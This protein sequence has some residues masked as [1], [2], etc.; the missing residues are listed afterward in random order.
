MSIPIYDHLTVVD[1][2]DD[3]QIPDLDT[4]YSRSPNPDLSHASKTK[5]GESI[6][7]IITERQQQFRAVWHDITGLDKVMDRLDNIRQQLLDKQDGINQSIVLHRGCTS[8]LWRFPP[9]IL[10][11][12]FVHCLPAETDQ[13]CIAPEL[14]PLL[15]TRVCRPWKEV[16]VNVPSLW[17]TLSVIQRRRKSWEETFIWHD[18]WLKRA[19]GLPLSLTIHCHDGETRLKSFLQSYNT[20]ISSL[21]LSAT[22]IP[23]E[24]LFQNLPALQHLGINWATGYTSIELTQC[25]SRLPC[26]LHSFKLRGAMVDPVAVT[27]FSTSMTHLREAEITLAQPHD[28]FHLLHLYPHLSSLDICVS[29]YGNS[30]NTVTQPL[31][32]FTHANLLSLTISCHRRRTPDSLADVFNA[33]TLPCL[34]LL[35]VRHIGLPHE[36]VKAFLVRSNC[37]LQR[38]AFGV[39]VGVS[40]DEQQA[41]YNALFPSLEVVLVPEPERRYVAC[42]N[43]R[44]A[45]EES[46][47]YSPISSITLHNDLA[48]TLTC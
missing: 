24:H 3:D 27:S 39:G 23:P 11:Q 10:S 9:E 38:L 36:E 48:H 34:C 12:I 25:I 33:L 16:A 35:E 41:K 43:W 46:I 42:S 17:C 32:S 19:K 28:F 22:R 13:F 26:T 21:K 8:A 44:D 18:L 40:K 20:Q 15:L 45:Y 4:P 29:S 14:A 30:E 1:Y 2:I 7:D 5:L 31:K 6:S 47:K 37:P